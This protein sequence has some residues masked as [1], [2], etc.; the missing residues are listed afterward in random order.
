MLVIL[1][2]EIASGKQDRG[3]KTRKISNKTGHKNPKRE[4]QQ[5]M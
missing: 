2:N 5:K 1:K 3:E 4:R